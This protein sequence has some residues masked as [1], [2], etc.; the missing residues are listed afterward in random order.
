MQTLR[1][2]QKETV[3][4][5]VSIFNSDKPKDALIHLPTGSGKTEIAF[6]FIRNFTANNNK[7][8]CFIVRRRHLV[9]QTF[10]R[11]LHNFPDLKVSILMANRID[12]NNFNSDIYV[13]SVDTLIK[14]I[15]TFDYI[16]NTC[17]LFFID[18]AH[19]T[20]SK[21]YQSILKELRSRGKY[22]VGMT[23]TPYK[24]NHK[25][26]NFW[27][28]S[29]VVSPVSPYQLL[30]QKY[31]CPI[32]FF[33]P[34]S[35]I[36][37]KN[38]KKS[39]NGDYTIS[40]AFKEV[41]KK[42]L[43]GSYEKYFQKYGIGSNTIT[44]CVNIQHSINIEEI[45][46]NLGQKNIFRI[47]CYIPYKIQQRIKSNISNAILLKENFHIINVN[48]FS[49]GMDIP[50]LEVGFMLRPTSSVVLWDQQIGRLTRNAEGK[51]IVTI[52]DFTK[53]SF[54]HGNMFAIHRVPE[55]TGKSRNKTI[56]P[57]KICKNCFLTVKKHIL[58]CPECGYKFTSEASDFSIHSLDIELKKD[59]DFSE[60][61]KRRMKSIDFKGLSNGQRS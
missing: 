16:K 21:S 6:D 34:P 30:E 37:Y 15:L 28:E 22:I 60:I 25:Y 35:S 32:R 29:N 57:Y 46:N 47:D 7:K 50:E 52:V 19:D 58:I 48:M 1:P 33:S 43:Y 42:V 38:L 45:L 51:D 12:H 20:T 27:T 5:L 59:F 14:R 23:A 49:T 18:E 24:V 10:K 41:N 31:L 53:N 26:H 36:I 8:V 3:K 44:F 4:N 13:C 61:V 54:N 39:S 2:Y 56:I 17:D 55:I 11:M 9:L 40:S